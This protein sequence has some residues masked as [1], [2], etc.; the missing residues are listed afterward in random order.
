MKLGGRA[1]PEDTSD[2]LST[3]FERLLQYVEGILRHDIPHALC[4]QTCVVGLSKSR[5]LH[6]LITGPRIESEITLPKD[7]QSEA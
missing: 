1:S 6:T 4:M 5:H 2:V 3:Q 7:M